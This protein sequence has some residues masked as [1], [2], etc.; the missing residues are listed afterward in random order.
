MKRI[1]VIGSGGA[2]KSTFAKRLGEILELKVIHL[3]SLFWSAGWVEM[4]KDQW[5]AMVEE[6]MKG[7]SWIL[8]GNYGGTLDLRLAACDAVIF[9]D[10]PRMT[11]LKRVF[12][13]RM[14]HRKESRPDMAPGCPER[15]N[16]EF[17]KYIWDYPRTR[18]P[19]VLKKI[20]SCS[21]TKKVAILRSQADIEGFLAK[22]SNWPLGY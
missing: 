22:A 18:K 19:A 3:D 9:L 1:L 10:I 5:R 7:D 6:L 8:D 13:R 12:K 20:E 11:C 21:E 17:I 16:W 15:I 4:P 2:G 14:S